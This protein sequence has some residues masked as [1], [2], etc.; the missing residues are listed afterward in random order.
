M[1]LYAE[2]ILKEGNSTCISCNCPNTTVNSKEQ[3][4][5]DFL[6]MNTFEGKKCSTG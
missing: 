2:K 4:D 1:H 5:P 6:T 3:Y